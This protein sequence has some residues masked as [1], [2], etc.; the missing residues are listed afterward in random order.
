MTNSL[1]KPFSKKQ[2]PTR[3]F[4]KAIIPLWPRAT[5][6]PEKEYVNGEK[7]RSLKLRLST[8]PGN[9]NGRTLT[10]IFKI[11]HSGLPEEWIL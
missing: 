5:W 3:A 6:V 9:V 2:K 11:S 10:K 8:E 1:S 7:M 4:A